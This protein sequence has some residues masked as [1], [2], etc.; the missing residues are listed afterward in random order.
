MMRYSLMMRSGARVLMTRDSLHAAAA[1]GNS[2]NKTQTARHQ[3]Y[4]CMR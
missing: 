4:D 3:R 2:H 1:A